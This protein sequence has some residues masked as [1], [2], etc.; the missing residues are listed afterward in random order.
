M[1]TLWL[2]LV[3]VSHPQTCPD[4]SIPCRHHPN[5]KSQVSDQN[6]EGNAFQ[7]VG[8][9]FS[10]TPLVVSSATTLV[11]LLIIALLTYNL[12]LVYLQTSLYISTSLAAQTVKRR[13]TM[14]DIRV[15][16]LGREDLLEK[17]TA[18]HSSVLAWKILWMEEPGRLQSMGSQR[19]GHD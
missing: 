5:C 18:T 11:R 17:G 16:S 4:A 14:Q 13:L 12:P 7:P 19:I 8:G 15:Q 3:H 1:I 9:A 2:Y 6:S 10:S